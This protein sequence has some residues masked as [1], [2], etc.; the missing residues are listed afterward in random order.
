VIDVIDGDNVIRIAIP[1]GQIT[2][3]DDVT[4][5]TD[6]ASR[7]RRHAHVLRRHERRQGVHVSARQRR[8]VSSSGAAVR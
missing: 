3:H 1:D 8:L 6:E 7:L 4:F 5:K 2:A